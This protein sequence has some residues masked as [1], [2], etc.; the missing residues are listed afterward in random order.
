MDIERLGAAT[1]LRGGDVDAEKTRER[2]RQR[3]LRGSRSR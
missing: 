3:R 2:T 1:I